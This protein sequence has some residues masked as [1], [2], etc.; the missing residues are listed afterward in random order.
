MWRQISPQ[1]LAKQSQLSWKRQKIRKA[2]KN[3]WKLK[4]IKLSGQNQISK[5]LHWACW[6]RSCQGPRSATLM[7]RSNAIWKAQFPSNTNTRTCRVETNRTASGRKSKIQTTARSSLLRRKIWRSNSL[8]FT[9][10]SL[11]VRNHS[12]LAWVNS[13]SSTIVVDRRAQRLT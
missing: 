1:R 6:P 11:S 4:S 8:L 3:H 13:V 5:D 9:R 7:G 12:L 10:K 2:K